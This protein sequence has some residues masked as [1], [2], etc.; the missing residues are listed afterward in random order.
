MLMA[1]DQ[2]TRKALEALQRKT[3]GEI[4]GN[5]LMPIAGH[6][7]GLVSS[8]EQICLVDGEWFVASLEP[9]QHEMAKGEVADRGLVPYIPTV[10]R[11]ERHGRGMTRT[12]WRP[13]LW[14]YML[15]K[16]LAERAHWSMI[17]S[18]RGV[19]RLLGQDGRP[20]P[21][22]PGKIEIIR[23]VE[24][25]HIEQEAHRAAMEAAERVAKAGGRSGLV[26]HFS[27]GDRV[28]IRNGPFASFY[29]ELE[30]AVDTHD[31]LKASVS[32]FGRASVIELS[33]HDIEAL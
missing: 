14:N 16:C 30:T 9:R 12:T 7:N 32:L 21:I 22:P 1:D 13:M 27:A 29:A 28:R 25:N 26:W 11:R 23:L 3:G 18:A 19:H 8:Q 10:P 33:A 15:V 17:T 20:K 31:R 5:K 24:A 2:I 6:L 4:V